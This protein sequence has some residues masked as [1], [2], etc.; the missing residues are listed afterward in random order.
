MQHFSPSSFRK[1]YP[2][3]ETSDTMLKMLS[4]VS[5]FF[6]LATGNF[7]Q[8]QSLFTKSS[9]TSG[10]SMTQSVNGKMKKMRR[11][12][13]FGMS[14]E[15]YKILAGIFHFYSLGYG[16]RAGPGPKGYSEVIIMSW[17]VLIKFRRVLPNLQ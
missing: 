14:I 11:F 16:L 10:N 6:L 4:I 5:N 3:L 7:V 2:E 1:L 17:R 12:F 8:F 9:H 13:P 15:L